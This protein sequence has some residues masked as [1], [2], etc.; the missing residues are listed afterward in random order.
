M[1][2]SGNRDQSLFDTSQHHPTSEPETRQ[3]SRHRETAN[4]KDWKPWRPRD[5][6]LLN[7][8]S[9]SSLRVH[10]KSH[11]EHELLVGYS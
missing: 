10:G 8:F 4:R 9:R 7:V 2:A 11:S 3:K 1:P 5:L 6:W